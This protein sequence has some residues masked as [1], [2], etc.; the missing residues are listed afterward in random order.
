MQQKYIAALDVD[1]AEGGQARNQRI[2]LLRRA[3]IQK[4]ATVEETVRDVGQCGMAAV[5]PPQQHRA[6]AGC[7]KTVKKRAG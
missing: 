6:V 2:P 4:L 7:H 1:E 5:L 3:A